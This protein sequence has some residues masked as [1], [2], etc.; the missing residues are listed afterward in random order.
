MATAIQQLTSFRDRRAALETEIKET[1]KKLFAEAVETL[2]TEYP[3]LVAFSWTQYTPYFN[4]GDSCEFG[5]NTDN[6]RIQYGDDEELDEYY[7]RN[8]EYIADG[9]EQVKDW[10]GRMVTRPKYKSIKVEHTEEDL[11]KKAAHNAISEFLNLFGSDDFRAMFGDHTQVIVSKTL[12]NIIDI[13]T[14]SY[15]HE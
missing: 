2:F 5:A 13:T 7:F 3:K 4:D 12:G 6:P 10:S 11:A 15:D 8:T 1:G 14:E 9:K